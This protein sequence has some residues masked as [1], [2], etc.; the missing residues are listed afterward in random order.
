AAVLAGAGA[1]TS[2]TPLDRLLAACHAGDAGAARAALAAAPGLP[3]EARA[4]ILEQLSR[5]AAH[6]TVRALETM[7]ALGF[8]ADGAGPGGERVRPG[9]AG[10]GRP[11]SVARLLARDVR[12]DVRD[13]TYGCSALA[14]ACHGSKNCR[15]ADADYIRVVDQLVAAGASREFA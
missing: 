7:L 4:E 9:A 15:T 2:L 11:D 8:P 14:W 3:W 5:V 10:R 1:D 12:V 6:G 13:A